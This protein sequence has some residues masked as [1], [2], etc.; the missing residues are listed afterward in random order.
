MNTLTKKAV[1]VPTKAAKVA[2]VKKAKTKDVNF[3][4]LTSDELFLRVLEQMGKP[5][6]V[7][8]MVTT[9][10]KSKLL[11]TAKRKL[12]A[13]LYASASHLNRDGKIKRKAV[14]K[15][16]FIYGLSGWKFGKMKVAA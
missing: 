15:S 5:S 14:N 2:D 3:K 8:D 11:S 1:K 12:L 6:L 7:R 4:G 10:K 13:K 16:M 9:I